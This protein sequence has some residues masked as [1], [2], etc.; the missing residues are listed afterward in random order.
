M[1]KALLAVLLFPLSCPAVAGTIPAKDASAYS[2][3]S[4][5][6]VGRAS[7]DRMPSGEIYLDL[8]GKGDGAPISCY[9]SRL[10][11]GSFSD[12]ARFD[13]KLVAVSGEIGSFR[14]RPE[15]FL[16][17]RS[18]IAVVDEPPAKAEPSPQP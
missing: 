10:N 5:T 7:V 16:T 18:Q 2:G 8:E 9:V 14:S 1:K 4:V 15:I 3:Q 13:G 11:A 17:V 12:I 6:V